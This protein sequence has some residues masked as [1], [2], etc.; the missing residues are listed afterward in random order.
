M[1]VEDAKA[2][3]EFDANHA[4]NPRERVIIREMEDNFTRKSD[5]ILVEVREWEAHLWCPTDVTGIV[6]VLTKNACDREEHRRSIFV[7]T[8]E[9]NLVADVRQCAIMRGRMGTDYQEL[10]EIIEHMNV[11]EKGL[12]TTKFLQ[13]VLVLEDR[14]SVEELE[15]FEKSKKR[16]RF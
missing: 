8:M 16:R 7:Q 13:E 2:D 6:H 12:L 14:I 10:Q 4:W 5:E 11:K 15:L 1:E 3:L 9:G